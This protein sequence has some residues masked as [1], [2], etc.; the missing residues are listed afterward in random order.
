MLEEM[1]VEN[2]P[3]EMKLRLLPRISRCHPKANRDPKPY[4][5]VNQRKRENLIPSER[6]PTYRAKTHE[7]QNNHHYYAL[8]KGTI[9]DP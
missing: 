5:Q 6:R 1:L 2:I 4:L 9:I 3:S 8:T 7:P